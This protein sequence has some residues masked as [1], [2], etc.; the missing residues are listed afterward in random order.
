VQKIVKNKGIFMCARE[1]E[2]KRGKK[3]CGIARDAQESQ[4]W[5]I[6][7]LRKMTTSKAS[8]ILSYSS[9]ISEWMLE[10]LGQDMC[11]TSAWDEVEVSEESK[12]AM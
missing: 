6:L 10:R 1:V 3:E 2:G 5:K 9:P 8:R 7:S 4:P 11:S 12:S